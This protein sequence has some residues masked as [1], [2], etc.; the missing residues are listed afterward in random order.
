MTTPHDDDLQADEGVNEAS[1]DS[2]GETDGGA[3]VSGAPAAA[4]EAGRFKDE[5]DPAPPV[6]TGL[7][8]TRSDAGPVGPGQQVEAGEG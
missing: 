1:A 3:G 7:P 5:S 4:S 6:D 2:T 8:E